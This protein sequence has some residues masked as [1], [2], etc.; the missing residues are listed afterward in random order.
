MAALAAGSMSPDLPYFV[1]PLARLDVDTHTAAAIVSVNVVFGLLMWG[2]WRLLATGLHALV[3]SDVRERWVLPTWRDFPWWAV[4]VAVA[5]GA[6]THLLWDEFT[7]FGRFG[8]EHI[9]MLTAEF[10]SPLGPL[11]GYR[12]AQY[13]SGIAGLL[14]VAIVIVRLPRRAATPTESRWVTPAVVLACVLSGIAG[15]VIKVMLA[16]GVGI[17]VRAIAFEGITGGIAA[18]GLV[19]VFDAITT[20]LLGK[21]GSADHGYAGVVPNAPKETTQSR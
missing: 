9:P 2:V 3:P 13:F 18:I 14:A 12:Y 6:A 4:C 21:R 17:G 19:L 11:M 15:S 7:H 16:G 8:T 5:V 1:T 20:M 10:P